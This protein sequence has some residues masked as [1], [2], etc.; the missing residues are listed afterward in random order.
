MSRLKNL[1]GGNIN[2][3]FRKDDD[4]Y[5]TLRP[6]SQTIQAL[7][8]HLEQQDVPRVPRA[9]GISQG[10]EIV[11]FIAG[12]TATYPW[13]KRVFRRSTLAGLARLMRQLHDAS[14]S[15][16]APAGA[17]WGDR[18]PGPPE[19]VCHNDIGPYNIIFAP[20]NEIGLIDFDR[21]ALGPRSWDL[22]YA[23]YRFAPL[24][25]SGNQPGFVQ[26]PVLAERARLFCSVYGWPDP[27]SLIELMELRLICEINWLRGKQQQD[28]AARQRLLAARHDF[29]YAADLAFL[30]RHRSALEDLTQ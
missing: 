13:P 28:L 12:K 16:Q 4:V 25:G 11:S 3:V 19:V 10:F 9:R 23:I 29:A 15:L 6:T 30:R 5:R 2:Q 22:A 8:R 27:A 1:T 17:V 26:L 20:T 7:L 21:S 18:L 14:A 24:C